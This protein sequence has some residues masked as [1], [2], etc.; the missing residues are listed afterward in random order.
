MKN[1][2][3]FDLGY[4]K[5]TSIS[6]KMFLGKPLSNAKHIAQ[7]ARNLNKSESLVLL[8][9]ELSLTGYTCEDLFHSSD[10]LEENK[11]ALQYL[12][13]ESI[14]IDSVL[15]VGHP[16][17]TSDGRLY[18]CASVLY[19]GKIL[20]MI[21]KS[22]LPNNSE[23]YEKR[24][25]VS[26]LDL[27]LEIHDFGQHFRLCKNQI[28]TYKNKSLFAVEICEDAW[29]PINPATNHCVNGGAQ[30][31][32]N[33]SASNELVGKNDYRKSLVMQH[34]ARL[35]CA[36]LYCSSGPWESSK[37]L[38]FGGSQLAYENGSYIGH[39]DRFSFEDSFMSVEF[40]LN[41]L[42]LERRRNVTY[43]VAKTKENYYYI[44]ISD[45]LDYSL[46]SISR[47]Y[48]QYPFVPSNPSTLE[49]R[50]DEILNIQS[51]GLARRL[52]SLNKPKMVLGLSGG[53]DST[54]ALLV[55]LEAIKKTG[56]DVK[57][58]VCISMPGFGTSDQTKSQAEILANITNV[59]FL[60][61]NI[62]KT[63]LSHFDDIGH[64]PKNYNVVYEN[65][66]ARERTQIL[67]DKA[68]QLKGIV[69]G[70]GDWSE[71]ALAW[72][73]FGGDHLSNYNVNTSVPKTLVQHLIA[74]YKEKRTSN[75]EFKNVLDN[76]LKTKISPE[77]LPPNENG[78][79]SQETESII[80]P[81]MLHDFFLFHYARNGFS[82][83]KIET[84][85]NLT[86]AK[87]FSENEINKWITICFDRFKK[88]QFKR[89][90]SPPGPML[91]LSWSS[92][93]AWR[94]P[95]EN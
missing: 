92:R 8:F 9:P 86:F 29:S 60:E 65:S 7:I 55:C 51:T 37:D 90:V 82:I 21:P 75:N 48:E 35:N 27:D 87:Y 5:M 59:D 66:Q 84:L 31:I 3:Y 16:Y 52:L 74:F 79:I 42:D 95:D 34:S 61:I 78:S 58:I 33:L 40:D 93:G 18:N 22:Y 57:D 4:V 1:I 39:S 72:M 56:Q 76:I 19:K 20:A 80:G 46:S 53:L 88:G 63:V 43:G 10:L 12:I 85:A 71:Q 44:D 73:T 28:I 24:W 94:M 83:R 69:V 36:Y 13:T 2:N 17:Q 25:F 91:G 47:K 50:S 30:I 89:T 62:T 81:Y 64:D 67:F 26:G 11:K 6:P 15:V 23:F 49:E 32:L 77:L 14:G 38:V 54:L 68:N 45:N 70:T 41:K